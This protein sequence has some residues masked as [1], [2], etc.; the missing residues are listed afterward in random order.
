MTIR[1]LICDDHTLFRTGI[2]SVLKEEPGIFVVG[3]ASDG[4]ELIEKYAKQ[5]PDVVIVDISMPGKTGIDTVKELK[6]KYPTVKVL[7]LTMLTGEQYIYYALDIGA[8][9]LVTKNIE[10]GELVFAINEVSRG[11]KYFGP[12]YD[13]E[14][15]KAILKKYENLPNL[16]DLNIQKDL[17]AVEDKILVLIS[18]GFQSAEIAEE[19]HLS[20]SS[21]D[22]YRTK[23][24]KKYD[25]PNSSSLIRF[26]L[27]YVESKNI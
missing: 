27:K 26:A 19:M 7:F 9:G 12:L 25:L 23:F 22:S 24:M 15:I 21:I 4:D 17:T 1:V 8:L 18:E 10:K 20:K 2:V 5:L 16:I 14:K 3:E 6:K 11:R 13:E